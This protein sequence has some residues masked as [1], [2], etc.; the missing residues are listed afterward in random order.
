MKTSKDAPVQLK[1]PVIKAEGN[2]GFAGTI[3][4]W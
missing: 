1:G 2:I 3:P 4:N